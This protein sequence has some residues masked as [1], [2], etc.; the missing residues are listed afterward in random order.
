[1]A[2]KNGTSWQAK[3]DTLEKNAKTNSS[4]FALCLKAP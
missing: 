4:P 2:I 3:S 1:M